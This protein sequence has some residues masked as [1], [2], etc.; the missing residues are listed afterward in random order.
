MVP[1][2][3]LILGRLPFTPNGKVDY[4]A[5]PLADHSLTGQ[6]ALFIAPRNDL[7]T[8]LCK[9]FSQ[10]LRLEQVDVEDNFFRLG[11]HSLSA[12]Q[13]AAR[14]RETFGV[15]LE[16]RSF[17]ESPTIAAL[18]KEIEFRT[19]VEDSK[20]GTRDTDREEIEL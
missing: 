10:V 17:F 9:I 3:F 13:A 16:L 12:A 20:L 4:Q 14:I 5:L 7:E 15:S 11:G 19:N 8:K 1:S 2:H 18:A 6:K